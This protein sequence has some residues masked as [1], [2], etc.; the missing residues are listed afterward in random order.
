MN[1]TQ[2]TALRGKRIVVAGAALLALAWSAR[3]AAPRFAA[4][5]AGLTALQVATGVSNVVLG[6][7]LAAAL[8]HVAGAALLVGLIVVRIARSLRVAAATGAAA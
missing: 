3:G 6:W 1:G 2:S 7:P 8:L 5:V 4:A